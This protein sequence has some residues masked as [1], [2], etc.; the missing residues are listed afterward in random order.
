MT[1]LE[2][3]ALVNDLSRRGDHV[4]PAASLSCSAEQYRS[5]ARR[6]GRKHGRRIR[7]YSIDDGARIIVVWADRGPTDLEVRAAMVTI[8]IGR[9]YDE[10]LEELRRQMLR[11]VEDA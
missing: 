4:V 2:D 10:V 3:Q 9:Q 11:P 1:Q 5:G 6:V 8:S 7:T